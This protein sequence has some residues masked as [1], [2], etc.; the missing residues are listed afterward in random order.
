MLG[1]SGWNLEVRQQTVLS[2]VSL[3][4]CADWPGSIQMAKAHHFLFQ[5]VVGK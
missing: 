5:Q 2:L 1:M 3:H 4:G